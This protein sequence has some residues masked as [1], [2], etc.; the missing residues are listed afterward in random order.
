MH[1]RRVSL[2]APSCR[3]SSRRRRRSRGPNQTRQEKLNLPEVL[4]PLVDLQSSFL[5][6]ERQNSTRN[7]VMVPTSAEFGSHVQEKP[8]DGSKKRGRE[9]NLLSSSSS[10]QQQLT[11]SLM[12]V[13]PPLLSKRMPICPIKLR[14]GGAGI[15]RQAFIK[16]K[17]TFFFLIFMKIQKKMSG[18]S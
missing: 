16:K 17:N 14:L 6:A 1:S 15:Q 2:L 9:T 11:V 4:A 3:S 12:A 13:A 8:N 10:V 7:R 18:S 5:P